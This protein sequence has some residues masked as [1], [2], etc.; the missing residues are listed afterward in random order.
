M[1]HVLTIIIA[2]YADLPFFNRFQLFSMLLDIAAQLFYDLQ[3]ILCRRL[4]CQPTCGTF[5]KAI[6]NSTKIKTDYRHAT[7]PQFGQGMAIGLRPDREYP[8]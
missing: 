7:G 2:G 5:A 1:A 4:R 3:N 6:A 8:T